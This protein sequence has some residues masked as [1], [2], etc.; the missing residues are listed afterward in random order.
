MEYRIWFG[1]IKMIRTKKP[2]EK[3]MYLSFSAEIFIIIKT[4]WSLKKKY[5]FFRKKRFVPVMKLF[6]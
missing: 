5:A 1:G 4:D 2:S 6:G 3:W